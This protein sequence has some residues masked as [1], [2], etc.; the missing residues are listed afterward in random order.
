M[1]TTKR[2]WWAL[3]GVAGFL[4]AAGPSQARVLSITPGNLDP[5]VTTTTSAGLVVWPK[6]KVS[7]ECSGGDNDGQMCTCSGPIAS[8]GTCASSGCPA[9]SC[10]VVS[11]TIVQLTN[12][13]PFLT[14][15]HCFYVNANGHCSNDP[16]TVCTDANFRDV[17]PPGG[18]CVP[19]WQETDFRL[20]LT[21]R[22]PISW[23][24]NQGL[25]QLPLAG[26]IV[27]GQTN[28][29]NIPP[30]AEVP[31]TGEL[32]CVQVDVTNEFPLDRNDLKGEA[33][34]VTI[35][36]GPAG[37][38][39]DASKYTAIGIPAIQGELADSIPGGARLNIG[40][41]DA[42]YNG[43]PNIITID[44]F[45]DGATVVTHDGSVSGE[46][47][48][49]LTVVPCAADFL[50][51][52]QNLAT[53]T[54][55][56]LIYNEFEQRFSTSTRVTCYREVNLADIDTR[57]GPDGD[58]FSIFSAAVQGTISGQS[59]MRAVPAGG[60]A[61]GVLAVL[62]ENWAAGQCS[63]SGTLCTSDADCTGGSTD[64]CLG[65]RVSTDIVN[66]Q[67]QGTRMEG[68]D[69]LIPLP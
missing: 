56:F 45:F 54:L 69:L 12:T 65:A 51:Q 35:G 63:V 46:V 44:H 6:I 64:A 61:N 32:R 38:V 16:A 28:E 67:F 19:G 23:S 39:V 42:D 9:G 2:F 48:S 15:A 20:T 29:G 5:G 4:L 59:R 13:S 60:S 33:T 58:A 25:P 62:Q 34:I 66:L 14:K 49:T 3:A 18:L 17:C 10:R 52:D 47:S 55:Q 26:Q 31:F 50:N 43:C 53:A 37:Q 22:Q 57:P 36:A 27:D 30:V 1:S 8:D 68:D 41:D 24:V 21:K 7:A 40:G 11:D